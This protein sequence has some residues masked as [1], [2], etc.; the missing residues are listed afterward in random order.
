MANPSETKE[1]D[2]CEH[3][4][5]PCEGRNGWKVGGMA[6]SRVCVVCRSPTNCG[7]FGDD[8]LWV[9]E[10]CEDEDDGEELTDEE[11]KN[12]MDAVIAIVTAVKEGKMTKEEGESAYRALLPTAR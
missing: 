5:C 6:T 11:L 12:A 8:D 2:G 9:C 1:C 4:S 7:N 10:D 3:G